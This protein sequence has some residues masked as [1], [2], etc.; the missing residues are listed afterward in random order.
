M[1]RL[2]NYTNGLPVEARLRYKSKLELVNGVD[3]LLIDAKDGHMPA[4]LPPMDAGDIWLY[5]VLQTSYITSKQFKAHN[6]ILGGL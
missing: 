5:L 4:S 6:Q 3:P 1:A 2:A